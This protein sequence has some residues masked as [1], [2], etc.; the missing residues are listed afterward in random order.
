MGQFNV[1]ITA[2]GPDGCDRRSQPGDKL[3]GRCGKFGCPDC[4]SY[5]F[6]QQMRQKGFTIAEAQITH[7]FGRSA[8]NGSPGRSDPDNFRGDR[9]RWKRKISRST[10]S[11]P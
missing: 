2:I 1:T 6:V 4:M 10:I 9:F 7:N 3:H 8:T 11:L 5:D